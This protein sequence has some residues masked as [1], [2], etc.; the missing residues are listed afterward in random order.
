MV[1][2]S[3]GSQ[4]RRELTPASVR[5]GALIHAEHAPPHPEWLAGAAT[6]LQRCGLPGS[7]VSHDSRGWLAVAD[8]D[9][10][11]QSVLADRRALWGTPA[12]P[13]PVAEGAARAQLVAALADRA[14]AHATPTGFDA[15]AVLGR[16]GRHRRLNIREAAIV[17][18]AALGRWASAVAG[19]GEGS[20]P[21]RLRAAAL[22]GVL[23]SAQAETLTEAFEVSLELRLMHHLDQ[24][25]AGEKPDD[26]LDPA[27][28]T[29]LTRGHLRDVFRAVTATARELEP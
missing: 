29:A 9:E 7:I 3:V 27:A 2:V 14:F 8:A 25:E 22:A 28:M 26:Y 11:G 19:A 12:Q 4:A 13:L 10:L 16:D 24:L 23:S 5:R 1:W 21:E 15:E 20:T 18:I 17:P 6:A